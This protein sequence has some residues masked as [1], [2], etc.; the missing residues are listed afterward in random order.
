MSPDAAFSLS[1]TFPNS[2]KNRTNATMANQLVWQIALRIE[3]PK[4]ALAPQ[5]KQFWSENTQIKLSELSNCLRAQCE[6]ILDVG[7]LLIGDSNWKIWTS[8]AVLS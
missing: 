5:T 3:I 7:N 2:T 4:N 1:A 8:C 6:F